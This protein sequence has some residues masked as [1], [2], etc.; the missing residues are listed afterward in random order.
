MRIHL[1]S[2]LVFLNYYAMIPLQF[3]HY[4]GFIYFMVDDQELTPELVKIFWHYLW[5]DTAVKVNIVF[6]GV[7]HLAE[8]LNIGWDM[9]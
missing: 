2:F 4:L 1:S 3:R 8:Y 6:L 7:K 5:K 9:G